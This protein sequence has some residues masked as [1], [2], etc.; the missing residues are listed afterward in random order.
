MTEQIHEVKCPQTGCEGVLKVKAS[1]P[2]GEYQCKCHHCTVKLSWAMHLARGRVPW[3]VLVEP[4]KPQNAKPRRPSKT[5][6]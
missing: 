3:L 1:L 4:E 6:R 5:Q 2:A